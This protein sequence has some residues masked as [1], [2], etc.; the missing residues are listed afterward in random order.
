MKRAFGGG[1]DYGADFDAPEVK[2]AALNDPYGAQLAARKES[3]MMN[4]GVMGGD[5]GGQPT[6]EVIMVPDKMVGLIIGRGGESITRLQ[7]ECG[8][9]IQVIDHK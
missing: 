4:A 9:K 7:A 3:S 6:S 5:V 8:C 1:A 2:K